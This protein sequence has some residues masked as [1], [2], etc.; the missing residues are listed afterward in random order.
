MILAIGCIGVPG[1]HARAEAAS[2]RVEDRSLV[3]SWYGA[4]HHGRSTASG[5]IFDRDG[6]TAA[7]RSL[8]FG[9]RLQVTNLRNGRTVL[10]RVNDR[11]PHAPNRDLDLSEAAA[12]QLGMAGRG[13]ALVQAIVIPGCP[14]GR[15]N[16]A[17]ASSRPCRRS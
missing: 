13:L 6:L 7:H 12:A 9:T 1:G 11:G 2:A 14:L 15:R 17:P 10:V 4:S 8:P 3:A 5:E 16:G